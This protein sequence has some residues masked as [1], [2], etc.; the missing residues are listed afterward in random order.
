MRAGVWLGLIGWMIGLALPGHAAERP[1]SPE[2]DAVLRR[3]VARA[4]AVGADAHAPT[5]RYDKRS[6]YETLA[7]DGSVKRTKEKVY[8]VTLR[9]GM[10][11]NRLV[12]VEGRTLPEAES[13]ALSEKENKWRE[14]YAGNDKGAA[15]DRVDVIINE[16][17]IARFDFSYQ[18]IEPVRGRPAH[19]L[20]FQPKDGPLPSERLLDRVI[21]LLHGTLWIDVDDD[22]ITQ[23]TAHTEGTL[24]LWGGILGSLETF[25][26]HIDRERSP[27]GPWFVRQTDV[28][29]RARRLFT[30]LYMRAREVGSG[31]RLAPDP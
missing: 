2:A 12:E 13:Q 14:T 24:R 21:N 23:A 15:T 1:A 25:E 11:F 30:M 31:V 18:G 26:M 7:P 20:T 19:R 27:L 29:I 10:T 4:H 17:L 6:L 22:E 16:E 28:T 9:R 3:L 5:L 8:Q